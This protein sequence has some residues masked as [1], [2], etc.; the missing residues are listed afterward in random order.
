MYSNDTQ[1]LNCLML[2]HASCLFIPHM[3]CFCSTVQCLF[4]CLFVCF[5]FDLFSARGYENEV[6]GSNLVHRRAE[7]CDKPRDILLKMWFFLFFSI[8]SSIPIL[9]ILDT[10]ICGNI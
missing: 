6:W 9:S 2:V 10:R 5:A 7:W 1:L 8:Q 3:F 4:V